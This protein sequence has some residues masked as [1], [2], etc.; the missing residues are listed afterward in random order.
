MRAETAAGLL[1]RFPPRAVPGHWEAT[2]QDMDTVMSRL[3]RGPFT[4]GTTYSSVH[5]RR[6]GLSRF[7]DWLSQYPGDTWQQRWLASP[8]DGGRPDWRPE[9]VRDRTGVPADRRT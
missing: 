4:T 8:A 6:R 3:L 1:E 5:R 2:G 7:L 9:A